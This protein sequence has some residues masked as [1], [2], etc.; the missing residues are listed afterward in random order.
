MGYDNPAPLLPLLLQLTTPTETDESTAV[1]TPAG[2]SKRPH[3]FLLQPAEQLAARA[4]QLQQ[5]YGLSREQLAKMAR[6]FPQTVFAKS[7]NTTKLKALLLQLQLLG[8]GSHTAGDRLAP[9]IEKLFRKCP[10]VRLV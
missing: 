8:D 5:L 1:S 3:S 6:Q 10:Q 4:V 7:S 9:E 2:L